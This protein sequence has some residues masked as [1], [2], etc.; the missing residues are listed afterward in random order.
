MVSGVLKSLLADAGH[1]AE[2]T[3]ETTRRIH[4]AAQ[5]DGFTIRSLDVEKTSGRAGELRTFKISVRGE[6]PL[7]SL[8]NW[9]NDLQRAEA[10]LR[11]EAAKVTCLGLPPDTAV[12]GEFTLVLFLRPS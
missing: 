1:S 4:Q 11:V 8:I 2:A 5:R 3:D 10:P 7:L 12:S 6:G 9:L